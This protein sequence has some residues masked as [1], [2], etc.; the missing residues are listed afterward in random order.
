MREMTVLT[1][2]DARD[3]FRL[4]GVRQQV[5]ASGELEAVLL[6]HLQ[7]EEQGLLIVDERLLE[8]F[9][10]QRLTE[11]ARQWHGLLLTLPAPRTV[12]LEEDEFQRLV[13]RAL[14]YHIRLQP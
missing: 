2:A 6:E 4:A 5:L 14:G 10:R 12:P 13:R 3:G 11:L 7:R 9:P 8:A 1:L